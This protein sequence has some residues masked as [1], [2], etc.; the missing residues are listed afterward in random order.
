MLDFLYAFFDLPPFIHYFP[1][2]SIGVSDGSLLVRAASGRVLS[3]YAPDATTD[4]V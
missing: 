2:T 4:S 1:G 3:A